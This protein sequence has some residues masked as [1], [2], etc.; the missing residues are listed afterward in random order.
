M[1]VGY[2]DSFTVYCSPDPETTSWPFQMKDG[3]ISRRYVKARYLMND[4]WYDV[5]LTDRN[6]TSDF[7]LTFALPPCDVLDIYRDTPKD[8]PIV[9]YGNGGTLL[10]DESRNAAARQSIHVVAELVDLAR[11]QALDCMCLLLSGGA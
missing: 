7:V 11:R 8:H 1:V 5:K 10:L 2:G 6:F 9:D 4:Q 3:Y